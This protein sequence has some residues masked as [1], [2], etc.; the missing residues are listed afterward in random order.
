MSLD[1]ALPEPRGQRCPAKG[2]WGPSSQLPAPRGLHISLVT[3]WPRSST[4]IV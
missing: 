4:H 2:L 1:P 3:L